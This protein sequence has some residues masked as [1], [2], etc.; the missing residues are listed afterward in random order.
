MSFVDAALKIGPTYESRTAVIH[1]KGDEAV[2]I[3]RNG[4]NPIKLALDESDFFPT[5]ISDLFERVALEKDLDFMRAER[6]AVELRNK[7]DA[8]PAGPIADGIV[9]QLLDLLDLPAWQRRHELYS[10]WISSLVAKELPSGF[11]WLLEHGALSYSFAGSELARGPLSKGEWA[12]WAELRRSL[13]SPVSKKRKR[14]VQPDYTLL[15]GIDRRNSSAALIVECK[16]YRTP[17]VRNF[18]DALIDYAAAHPDAYILLANY[19]PVPESTAAGFNADRGA[20]VKAFGGVRPFAEGLPLFLQEMRAAIDHMVKWSEILAVEALSRERSTP[21]SR[22]AASIG[23]IWLEWATSAD[24]DLEV[25]Y[26]DDSQ[27]FDVSY[28]ALGNRDQ[29]PWMSLDHDVR[30][31][32]GRETVRV[33]RWMLG[34]YDVLIHLFDGEWPAEVIVGV[35]VAGNPRSFAYVGLSGSR[36]R[37]FTIDATGSPDPVVTANWHG[38]PGTVPS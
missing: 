22:P 37:A 26:R 7:L 27:V 9:G 11:G 33:T 21:E 32:P 35:E 5:A 24:L 38:L 12:F 25:H 14:S 30:S 8:A 3:L 16:Q 4:W 23:R 1:R 2:A 34:R 10:I 17:S 28:R 20:P 36:H 29:V 13:A 18:K 31:G 15:S 6:L 19:G